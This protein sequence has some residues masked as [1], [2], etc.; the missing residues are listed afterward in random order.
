MENGRWA[1]N[2]VFAIF[3]LRFTIQDAFFSILLSLYQGSEN[4]RQNRGGTMLVPP[5]EIAREYHADA[6]DR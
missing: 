5:R 1:N 4:A 2:E 6:W 3:H